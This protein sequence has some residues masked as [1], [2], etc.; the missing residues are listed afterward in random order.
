M[1]HSIHTEVIEIDP[2]APEAATIECAAGLIRSG[3]LVVFPTETVYG[4]GERA[5]TSSC[6]AYL[7]SERKA[8]ERSVDCAYCR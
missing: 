8:I 5:A 6:R 1:Q 3:E 4:L 2:L 7:C